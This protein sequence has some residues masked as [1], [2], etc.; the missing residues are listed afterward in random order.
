MN[1][2]EEVKALRARVDK[3]FNCAQSLLVPFAEELKLTKDQAEAM[4]AFLGAGMMHGGTC[5]ALSSTL[6]IL[7]A[8]G[9]DKQETEKL[10]ARFQEEH[11]KTACEALLANAEARGIA[12]KTNCD[13]LVFEM[14]ELLDRILE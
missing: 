2:M 8:K 14:A 1:H 7:G 3:H 10:I 4:G 12:R 11:T 6:M 9:Y 5:G 13:G